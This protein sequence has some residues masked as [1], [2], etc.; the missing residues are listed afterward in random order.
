MSETVL[1]NR[2]M[3]ALLQSGMRLQ[4]TFAMKVPSKHTVM[5]ISQ[6]AV[7]YK[8]LRLFSHNF[9]EIPPAR[10]SKTVAFTTQAR[11]FLA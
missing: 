6:H 2:C 9:R 10:K 11:G 5:E 3:V 8:F 1:L 4:L 7:T